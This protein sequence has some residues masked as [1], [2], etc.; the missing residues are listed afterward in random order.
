MQL[1]ISGV[2]RANG[3]AE[4]VTSGVRFTRCDGG[5]AVREGGRRQPEGGVDIEP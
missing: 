2:I 5:L 4:V 1:E 3:L